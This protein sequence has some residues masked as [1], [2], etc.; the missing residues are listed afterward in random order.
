MQRSPKDLFPNMPQEVFDLW[1]APYIPS[2][3]WP[4]VTG[5]E[6]IPSI[7]KAFFRFKPL[8]YWRSLHWKLEVAEFSVVRIDHQSQLLA[9]RVL[10]SAVSI[11][12]GTPTKSTEFNASY[13][14][15]NTHAMI[16]IQKRRFQLPVICH[17]VGNCWDMVDGHHRLAALYYTIKVK[18]GNF[19]FDAWVGHVKTPNSSSN[20]TR[21]QP[22]AVQQVR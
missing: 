2:K 8:I 10:D 13:D 14:R 5:A 22:R 1:I 18:P 16:C 12:N 4:F 7:W 19:I 21:E 11:A 6:E 9:R 20:R 3:G 15:F 17:V